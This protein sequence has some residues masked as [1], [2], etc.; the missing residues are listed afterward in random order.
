MIG[1]PKLA[2]RMG[3]TS[4]VFGAVGFVGLMAVS[5]AMD[6]H[7]PS[8]VRIT[9]PNGEVVREPRDYLDLATQLNSSPGTLPMPDG[10]DNPLT[11]MDPTLGAGT[12]RAGGTTVG[13]VE[14]SRSPVG[15]GTF[16]FTLNPSGVNHVGTARIKKAGE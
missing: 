7:D 3:L 4:L 2:L 16:Q 9:L 1:N 13:R 8:P 6:N 5:I 14:F 10:I 15:D 12:R 11:G